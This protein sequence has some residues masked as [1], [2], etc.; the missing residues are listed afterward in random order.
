[1]LLRWARLSARARLLKSLPGRRGASSAA[2][3]A[4]DS[5]KTTHRKQSGLRAC[6]RKL[7][8]VALSFCIKSLGLSFRF[9]PFSFRPE[10]K[11]SGVV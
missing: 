1:L 7:P 6:F 9:H 5:L 3:W 10:A 4:G 2:A 8:F 11:L